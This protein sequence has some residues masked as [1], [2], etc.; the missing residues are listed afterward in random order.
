MQDTQSRITSL[1]EEILKKIESQSKASLFSKDF[2]Y[3]SIMEWSMKNEK[4]KTNMF[5]FVDVLPALN[6]GDVVAIHLNVYFCEGG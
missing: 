5:R 6:S 1:G 4:F 3:G 2:W